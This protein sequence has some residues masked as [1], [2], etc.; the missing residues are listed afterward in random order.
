MHDSYIYCRNYSKMVTLKK[1]IYKI[2]KENT[3][4]SILCV[5]QEQKIAQSFCTKIGKTCLCFMFCLFLVEKNYYVGKSKYSQDIDL[6]TKKLAL[7]I[8]SIS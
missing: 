2:P 7:P 4:L 8:V 6:S 1:T 3:P 5:Q